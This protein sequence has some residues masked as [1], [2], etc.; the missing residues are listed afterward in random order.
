MAHL[1]QKIKESD[2]QAIEGKA[3][4]EQPSNDAI[5]VSIPS[6]TIMTEDHDL[7]LLS[8]NNPSNPQNPLN[9]NSLRKWTNVFLVSAQAMLSAIC[10][11]IPAAG[12]ANIAREFHLTSTYTPT[13]PVG[14]YVLGLALGPLCLG[15]LSEIYGRRTIYLISFSLFTLFN[16]GCATSPN[17]TALSILRLASGACGSA[18]PTLGA[19]SI[20]DMFLKKDRGKAQAVYA[21]GPTLGPVIGPLIGSFVVNR[22]HGWRWLVWILAIA[23]GVVVVCSTF[24]LRETYAPFLLRKNAALSNDATEHAKDTESPLTVATIFRPFRLLLFSPICTII[25][26][27]MA[28]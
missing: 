26:L 8:W 4:S 28:L 24:L 22:T 16:I 21:L 23:S 25:S 27:Y 14:M 1:Q 11:T 2:K 10:S 7:D 17:I 3:I 15:P 13:L 5:T 6:P 20:G 19:A 12:S 9:W 18:G